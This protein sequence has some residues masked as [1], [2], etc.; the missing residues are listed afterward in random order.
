MI[1]IKNAFNFQEKR[2]LI[3]GASSG[4]GYGIAQAFLSAGAHVH[5]TGTRT[6]SDYDND[7]SQMTFHS[8]DVQNGEAVEALAKK[9]DQL[10]IL[11]NS[12]GTVLYQKQEFARVGF[13]KI[14]TINLIGVMHLCTA[15]YP[16]LE[17]S[18]GN[19]IKECV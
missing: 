3:T 6:M 10:D 15:F 11:I 17:K 2:V 5:I 4:I 12:V 1:S 18:G 19:I 8:L 13:E 7:F 14:L 16:Q 9:I